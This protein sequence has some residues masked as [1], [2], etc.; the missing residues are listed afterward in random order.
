MKKR[1]VSGVVLGITIPLFII[2]LVYIMVAVYYSGHFFPGTHING[3]DCSNMSV[4]EVVAT[5]E[6]E[7]N[8]YSLRLLERDDQQE[9]LSS[10]D[11]G[12][13]ASY[14]G[15]RDIKAKENIFLWPKGM[16]DLNYYTVDS[17]PGFHEDKLR[18]ALSKLQCVAGDNIKSPKDAYIDYSDGIKVVK[19]VQ[20]TTID[21]DKLYEAVSQAILSGTAKLDLSQSGCYIAPEVTVDSEE[22]QKLA[23]PINKITGVTITLKLV[24]GTTEVI[25]EE[26][27]SNW[28][29]E[30]EDGKVTVDKEKVREYMTDMESKYDTVH[31]TREFVNSYGN[32]VT[33]AAGN[34]GWSI[35]ANNETDKIVEELLAGKDVTRDIEYDSK[36][37]TTEGNGIGDTYVEIS[38]ENQY[39]W[40]YKNGELIVETN[41]VTGDASKGHDTPKGAF[42]LNNKQM[43]VTLTSTNADD[44]YESKVTYW[45]PFIGNAYGLHDSSWRGSYGGTIYIYNGSH[46]CVNTPYYNVQAI[47]E[48]IEIGTPVLIY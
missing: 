48:N 18:E 17:Q 11:I 2:V 6:E 36:T 24:D 20:G 27:S 22:F 12:F 38:I 37:M 9:L 19:E 7:D 45:L 43:Y 26:V 21:T 47:Y 3:L 25:D 15:V 41:I 23:E 30:D 13:V 33:L 34:Y 10:E 4:E 31:Q 39:M 42:T 40:F 29:C 44:P 28:L 1:K 14:E 16:I 8:S 46:G 35:A 32:T 5:L